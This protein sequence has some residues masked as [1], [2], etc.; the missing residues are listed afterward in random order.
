MTESPREIS[1]RRKRKAFPLGMMDVAFQGQVVAAQN[2]QAA[3]VATSFPLPLSPSP[4]SFQP[5][6]SL[7]E[8]L[9]REEKAGRELVGAESVPPR[10]EGREREASQKKDSEEQRM[11]KILEAEAVKEVL[12]MNEE[13]RTQIEKMKTESQLELTKRVQELEKK[14]S[15]Q[16]ESLRTSLQ[17]LKESQEVLMAQNAEREKREQKEKEEKE[18]KEK[19]EKRER[20]KRQREEEEEREKKEEEERRKKEREKSNSRK[21]QREEDEEEYEE[22]EEEDARSRQSRY[23]ESSGDEQ[24]DQEW[25]RR[26]KHR[27][28]DKSVEKAE[29]SRAG[30]FDIE[31]QIK[32]T[33]LTNA[34]K[35]RVS[36]GLTTGALCS[37][38]GEEE[39]AGIARRALEIDE[40]SRKTHQELSERE[41]KELKRLQTLIVAIDDN[42]RETILNHVAESLFGLDLKDSPL[43]VSEKMRLVALMSR[44]MVLAQAAIEAAVNRG[45]KKERAKTPG[46]PWARKD[47]LELKGQD[48]T[49]M[50][51]EDIVRTPAVWRDYIVASA[52]Q[53][54]ARRALRKALEERYVAP[55]RAKRKDRL[56]TSMSYEADE[57]LWNV[58]VLTTPRP[59]LDRIPKIK[60]LHDTMLFRSFERLEG[61]RLFSKEG[62][63]I[64]TAFMKKVRAE[65]PSREKD[66]DAILTAARQEVSKRPHPTS[67]TSE[68]RSIIHFNEDPHGDRSQRR[69][70]SASTAPTKPPDPRFSGRGPPR[71]MQSSPRSDTPPFRPARMPLRDR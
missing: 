22:E 54:E 8:E 21:R 39:F 12:K 4:P 48:L 68:Y 1:K 50:K 3:T 33:H 28:E 58:E 30:E 44:K 23:S 61:L 27:R 47:I 9:D 69:S 67:L 17:S 65:P 19:K 18:R 55:L 43:S 13:L 51:I 42:Q 41:A 59:D 64:G 20:E 53:T 57:I 16:I 37:P 66:Y 10:M 31:S 56:V 14:K 49:S 5:F 36:E 34:Y 40:E 63:G 71:A 32:I 62:F 25:A 11:K 45:V 15:S 46:V 7:D 70:F 38:L 26:K 29:R 2:K 24:S 35:R 60:D 6:L 52:N